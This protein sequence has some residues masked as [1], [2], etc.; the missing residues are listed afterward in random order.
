MPPEVLNV[1]VVE[2]FSRADRVGSDPRGERVQLLK[3]V[4][5]NNNIYSFSGGNPCRQLA[6]PL[7]SWRGRR[8]R[9]GDNLGGARQQPVEREQDSPWIDECFLS[10]CVTIDQQKLD[11][12]SKVEFYQI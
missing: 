4:V 6:K 8:G 10:I 3:N 5:H 9:G 12:Q 11:Q 1:R 7:D 2:A